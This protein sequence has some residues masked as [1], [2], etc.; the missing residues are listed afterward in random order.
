MIPPLCFI[1]DPD[2]PL[3][4]VQQAEQAARGGAAWVQ[5]RHKT[6]GDPEFAELAKA[7]RA[8]LDPLSV[9]LVVN[10]RVEVA[11][12]I[13][14]AALHIGQSDGGPRAIRDRIGPDM[15]LGLSI[16]AQ[17]QVAPVP[18]DCVS[19]LGVGPVR[20]TGSKADAAPPIGFDG[21]ARIAGATALPCMAIGGLRVADVP[22]IKAAGCSGAAV[23][24][25]LSRAPDIEA[26]AHDFMLNWS[27]G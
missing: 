12:G 4:I 18:V 25:A 21:L 9:V 22:A 3:P 27:D 7:L 6:L 16:E 14:A 20:V 19:Y 24:S 26:A 23:I 2:A 11:R 1:T 8:I 5:L 13:G 17:D 10:D 15:I